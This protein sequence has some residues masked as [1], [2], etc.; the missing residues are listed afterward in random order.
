MILGKNREEVIQNILSATTRGELNCKVES[1]DPV[2]TSEQAAEIVQKYLFSR[3]KAVFRMKSALARQMANVATRFLNSDTEIVGL[4]T[5]KTLTGGAIITCNHFSPI[6]NTIVRH[7]IR[8]LKKKRINIVSQQSN[9]AMNGFIGFLMNY[10]DTIPLSSNYNF[11]F[12]VLG[13]LIRNEEY[14][15]IYPEQEMWFHYRKPRP[16]MR[17]A[18]Y[19]A[20]KLEVPIVSC[21]IEMQDLEVIDKEQ[22]RKVKYV[23]HIL[24]ILNPDPAKSVRENATFLCSR[25]YELKKKAYESCY[26]KVLDYAFEKSDIAGWT[27]ERI[28][29]Y[30][31]GEHKIL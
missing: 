14:V 24:D 4:E 2:I 21:F 15:L 27:A 5:W 28:S 18:Y 22:F 23:M 31:E 10:A 6:D 9:F 8:K 11:M 19:F 25:D 12:D 20:A 30:E 29:G 3:N 13:E 7:M 16:L 17:G 26:G 1:D